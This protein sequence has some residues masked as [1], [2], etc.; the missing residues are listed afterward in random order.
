MYKINKEDYRRFFFHGIDDV[1][2]LLEG[3]IYF[4]YENDLLIYDQ[5]GKERKTK[6]EEIVEAIVQGVE[7]LYLQYYRFI[8]LNNDSIKLEEHN[9]ERKEEEERDLKQDIRQKVEELRKTEGK[10]GEKKLV[11]KGS[12]IRYSREER[13]K[14]AHIPEYEITQE[15]ND[16]KYIE[17]VTY[18]EDDDEEIEKMQQEGYMESWV[19]KRNDNLNKGKQKIAKRLKHWTQAVAGILKRLGEIEEKDELAYIDLWFRTRKQRAQNNTIKGV[20]EE[21]KQW[22]DYECE[23]IR[24]K[25]QKQELEKEEHSGGELG[26]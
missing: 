18:E 2:D 6:E 12:L 9:E 3:I 13:A 17:Y 23:Q 25:R 14:Y 10:T 22:I 20:T 8:E 1:D 24:R 19:Q 7:P 11:I 5:T 21:E 4:V 16:G 15:E 26:L